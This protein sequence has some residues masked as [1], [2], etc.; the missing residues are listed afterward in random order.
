LTFS[1]DFGILLAIKEGHQRMKRPNL[2]VRKYKHSATHPFLL[3]LRPWGKDKGRLFFKTRAEAEAE[4]LRQLTALEIHGREAM[5]LP[6]H[7]ISDFISA[8]KRLAEYKHTINDAADFLI[9][10]LEQIRRCKV[11]IEELTAELIEAKRKAGRSAIYLR[12]LKNLL[13]IFGQSFGQHSVAAVTV[14]EI[15]HWLN[16]RPGSLKSRMNFRQNISVLFGYAKKRRMIADNPVA[17]TE[18]PRLPDAPPEILSVEEMR[19]LL[20]AAQREAPDILPMLALGAFAGVRDAEIKRLDWSEVDLV[21]GHVEIKAAKAKSSRRRI[22]SLQPNLMAWLR[23]YSGKTGRVVPKGYRSSL[24]RV[25]K[26]AG[27]TRWKKNALRHSFASYRLAATNNAAEVA[28]ELGHESSRMLYST[29]RELVLPSE[30]ERYWTVRPETEA[31]NVV[32]FE[33][34]KQ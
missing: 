6:A 28:A 25:R 13:A 8:R 19:E 24:E 21:R 14:E 26:T 10:H 29:Y 16:A 15:D 7:E 1:P 5:A 2:K 11:T 17:H 9:N 20:E 32:S 33:S 34:Q 27:I 4:R 12:D 31:A 23:T 18:K 3:D 22:I 30:A